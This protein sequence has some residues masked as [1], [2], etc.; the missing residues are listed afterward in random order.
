MDCSRAV[1]EEGF[2]A[3]RFIDMEADFD[4]AGLKS[5]QLR[6]IPSPA[7]R[8]YQEHAGI[9]SAAL[10]VDVVSL[11]DQGNGLRCD[12]LKIVVDSA[13]VPVREKLER[14]FGRR[15]SAMLLFGLV[16]ENAE[17]GK[18]VFNLLERTEG[19]LT[20]CGRRAIV[21]CLCRF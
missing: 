8:F 2:V 19:R 6:N 20:I 21:V 12:H 4:V 18:I 3:K 5:R 15:G 9:H 17:G 1:S 10:D 11:V 16:F 7:D 14:F 13:L